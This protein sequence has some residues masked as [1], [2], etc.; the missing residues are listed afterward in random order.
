MN[1]E[2]P[3]TA[4]QEA[5]EV[6]FDETTVRGR[7]PIDVPT[8]AVVYRFALLPT[9]KPAEKVREG[10]FFYNEN[11]STAIVVARMAS[12]SCL[13]KYSCSLG[14]RVGVGGERGLRNRAELSGKREAWFHGRCSMKRRF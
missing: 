14:K 6:T 2:V 8:A 13:C 11:D 4:F 10:L 3:I 1:E 5:E 7:E 12:A 9:G